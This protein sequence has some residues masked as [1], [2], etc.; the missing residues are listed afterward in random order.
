[1][2][3]YMTRRK[4]FVPESE[5]YRAYDEHKTPSPSD[6]IVEADFDY[7][8]YSDEPI[9]MGKENGNKNTDAE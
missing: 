6:Y 8:E 7:E 9:Y 5:I 1:M 4:F 2:K 3:K